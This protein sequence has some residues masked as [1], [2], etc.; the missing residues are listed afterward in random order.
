LPGTARTYFAFFKYFHL[1]LGEWIFEA[2]YVRRKT[3]SLP[4]Q[5]KTPCK[6]NEYRV[7]QRLDTIIF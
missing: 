3:F 7:F 1:K 4:G 6:M 5:I 2:R